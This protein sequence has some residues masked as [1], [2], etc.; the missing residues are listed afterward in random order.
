VS[1]I[2]EGTLFQTAARRLTGEGFAPLVVIITEPLRFIVLEQLED[3]GLQAAPVSIAP[4]PRTTG[5]A[6][7]AALPWMASVGPDRAMQIAPSDHASEDDE[8]FRKCVRSAAQAAC[9][10]VVEFGITL[11]HAETGY[12]WLR[13]GEVADPEANAPQDLPD[14][15]ENPKPRLPMR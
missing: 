12:G 13:F 6:V 3:N 14:F 7:A 10:Y 2:G 8:G 1:L 5:P 11:T 15:V 4:E 9:D